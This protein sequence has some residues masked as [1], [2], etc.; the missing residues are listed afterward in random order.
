M[1][2]FLFSKLIL[3]LKY[4]KLQSGKEKSKAICSVHPF[5]AGVESHARRCIS[6]ALYIEEEIEVS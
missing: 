2:T 3:I 1:D 5:F 6:R 4:L